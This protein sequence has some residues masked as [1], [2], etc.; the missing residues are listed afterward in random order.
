MAALLDPYYKNLDFIEIDT[1]K[2]QIIQKLHDEIESSIC[3]HKEYCQQ[4]Q[5]KTKKA[6]LNMVICDEIMNYLSLPLA[7]EI[8]NTLDWWQI[9]FQNFPK[10]AKLA[11]KYLAIPATSVSSERLFSNAVFAQEWDENIEIN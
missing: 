11:R 3:S 6:I 9:C 1:K 2:E 5:S 7:L 8:E 4:R 10:L